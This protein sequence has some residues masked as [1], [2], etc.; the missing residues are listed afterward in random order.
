MVDGYS[1]FENM[2]LSDV[3][4]RIRDLEERQRLL[5]DR[6]LL[7]GQNLIDFREE[8]E[9]DVTELKIMTRELKQ[10]LKKI[11]HALLRLTDEVDKRARSSDVELLRKQA[12]MFQKIK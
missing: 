8:T 10:D 2:A 9:K 5:K 11:K 12:K 7:I 4:T 1:G 3:N 6:T